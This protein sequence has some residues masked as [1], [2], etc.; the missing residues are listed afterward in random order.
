VHA[1][2]RQFHDKEQVTSP[3]LV[4]TSIVVKS[5]E[6]ST[7]QWAA[8]K[9]FQVGWRLRSGAGSMPWALRMSATVVSDMRCPRFAGAP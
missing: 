9:V 6:A 1:S 8:G 3:L 7:S 5:T 4:Q 2:R